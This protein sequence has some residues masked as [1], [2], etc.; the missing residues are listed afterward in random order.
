M[1]PRRARLTAARLA[2]LAFLAMPLAAA[3]QLPFAA[4]TPTPAAEAPAGDPYRR[5]TPHSAFLGFIQ[6]AQE[7]DWSVASE[8]LQFKGNPA[9][10][11]KEAL[12]KQ[13]EGVLDQAFKGDIENLSRSPLG[14]ID[15][16]LPPDLERAG[17]IVVGGESMDVLLTRETPPDGP[18][19]W[20][21]SAQTLRVVPRA[22]RELNVPHIEDKLPE[23]FQREAGPLRLWQLLGIVVLLPLLFLLVW[24]AL[25]VA[26][27]PVRRLLEKS[28][29]QGDLREALTLAKTPLAILLALALHRLVVPYLS[30]P[31]L[32]R[33]RYGLFLGVLVV[34]VTTW[35]LFR[36]I[37]SLSGVARGRFAA[38]GSSA[39]PTLTL[40]RRLLKTGV[41]LIALLAGLGVFGVNLTAVLAGLGIGGV[42][43]AFAAKTSIENIF[44]GF[45]VL[46]AKI[47]R[48]GDTC[49]IDAFI[50]TIEDITL[51]ATRLRTL[52]RS[53]VNIPNGTLLTREIENLSRRDRFLFRHTLGLRY[54]TTS[55]Q[56]RALLEALQ[57]L[58]AEHPRIAPED[59]RVRFVG[60]AA[61]SLEIEL[62]A[63]VL[64]ADW[65]AF[66]GIQ[67]ELLLS[68]MD[69][70]AAAGATMAFPSQT[71]YLGKDA[72]PGASKLS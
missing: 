54:E 6:A 25:S 17:Q 19:I 35:L 7:A 21:I 39:A 27:K 51:F 58:L 44:G 46:G 28:G 63:Y 2:A 72:P 67:E 65:A 68:V 55:A 9:Q 8:Y 20:L 66:L 53:V 57:K 47:L 49:R 10:A 30:L 32:F 62:F 33:Y 40:G 23:I 15:D 43:L 16:G 45:T 69:L 41:L 61:S 37:D 59:A 71:L 64:A 22:H 34:S 26:L 24:L 52:D 4:P 12:A 18:A 70:V 36:L 42:A 48:V 38:A 1:L 5:E 29:R 56:L 11:A 31:L 14:A 50:G 60:Y 3:A 13:L